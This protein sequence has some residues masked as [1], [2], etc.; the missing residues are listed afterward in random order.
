M[1]NM[2][3]DSIEKLVN[4]FVAQ[5]DGFIVR[6]RNAVVELYKAQCLT[7]QITT[8]S[9]PINENIRDTSRFNIA[10]PNSHIILPVFVISDLEAEFKVVYSIQLVLLRHES[11]SASTVKVF[12]VLMNIIDAFFVCLPGNIEH[13]MYPRLARQE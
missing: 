8:P 5:H 12:H 6:V 9:H 4:N 3:T 13:A 2:R 7:L 1:N 11:T 10:F